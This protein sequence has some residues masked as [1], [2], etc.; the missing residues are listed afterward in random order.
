MSLLAASAAK[1]Q[2]LEK[3][4]DHVVSDILRTSLTKPDGKAAQAATK[5]LSAGD[6]G[7]SFLAAF[8]KYASSTA[9]DQVKNPKVENSGSSI[10][11]QV[12]SKS[13]TA[14][15]L[16]SVSEALKHNQNQLSIQDAG[17]QQQKSN[18]LLQQTKQLHQKQIMDQ[19]KKVSQQNIDNKQT[20]SNS[21][22]AQQKVVKAIK[23]TPQQQQMIRKVGQSMPKS[24]QAVISVST[25]K[26]GGQHVSLLNQDHIYKQLLESGVQGLGQFKPPSQISPTS[27]KNMQNVPATI[28]LTSNSGKTP[29]QKVTSVSL[30]KVM[31]GNSNSGN[32]QRPS[33]GQITS[34]QISR[35]SPVSAQRSSQGQIPSPSVSGQRTSPGQISPSVSGQRAP[36]GQNPSPTISNQRTPSQVHNSSSSLSLNSVNNKVMYSNSNGQNRNSGTASNLLQQLFEANSGSSHSVQ[37]QMTSPVSMQRSPQKSSQ[38][39]QIWSMSSMATS[40]SNSGKTGGYNMANVI[41]KP[42]PGYQSVRIGSISKDLVSPGQIQRTSMHAQGSYAGTPTSPI[43]TGQQNPLSNPRMMSGQTSPLGH[44]TPHEKSR[45]PHGY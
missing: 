42:V 28:I 40:A 43:S 11:Q 22:S 6:G 34:S 25:S 1:Q 3:S 10:A 2:Y 21:S 26:G 31:S 36:Q 13:G 24:G 35:T 9:E 20:N 37:K 45:S 7:S 17:M 27:A 33:T 32:S 16:K 14:Q 19:L 39:P 12:Q 23:I 8:E 30:T 5:A 4:W 18:V 29:Q 44:P 38:G 15:H 41:P